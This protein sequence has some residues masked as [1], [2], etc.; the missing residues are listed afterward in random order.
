MVDDAVL[1][2]KRTHARPLSGIS[3]R[4]GSGHGGVVGNGISLHAVGHPAVIA[5]LPR[6]LLLIV[7]GDA[8]LALLLFGERDLEVSVE[9]AAKGGRPGE[10]PAH[11]FLVGLNLR[12]RSAR[13]R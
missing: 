3:R 13:Y 12:E 8:S 7:I 11:P 10:R 4:V 5:R 9:V 1:A 6:R 2:N